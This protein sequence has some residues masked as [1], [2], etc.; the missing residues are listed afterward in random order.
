[1]VLVKQHLLTARKEINKAL[2]LLEPPPPPPSPPSPPHKPKRTFLP[3]SLELY[4]CFLDWMRKGNTEF[5][6]DTFQQIHEELKIERVTYFPYAVENKGL[7][8]RFAP[9]QKKGNLWDLRKDNEKFWEKLEE[10]STLA[11]KKGIFLVPMAFSKYQE[12]PFLKNTNNVHGLW[13]EKAKVFQRRYLIR[14]AKLAKWFRLSNE[15]QH[16]NHKHG[17]EIAYRHEY[18]YQCIKDWVRLNNVINDTTYSD[19][20]TGALCEEHTAF[21]ITL[22]KDEYDRKC[23]VE[24][25]GMCL[26][27][28]HAPVEL[29]AD[30]TLWQVITGCG[31]RKFVLSTDGTDTGSGYNIPG[32]EFRNLSKEELKKFCLFIWNPKN[33]KG[34]KITIAELPME[35]FFWNK[36]NVL[37]EDFSRLDFSRLK[38]ISEA[39]KII[40]GE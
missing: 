18:W 32:T 19:F 1:M 27:K 22:G 23:W 37:E 7:Y 33:N 15:V 12:A 26:P 21:G 9:W 24:L 16:Y 34:R 30:R 5:W 6:E 8:N 40:Q 35:I 11:K 10:F 36:N 20:V 39:Y 31:W 13:D 25:H 29:G 14:L 17:F 3:A 4:A 28:L 2:R 38:A